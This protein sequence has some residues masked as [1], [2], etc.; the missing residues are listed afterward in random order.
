MKD[1]KKNQEEEN[2]SEK[3]D[4]QI[5]IIGSIDPIIPERKPPNHRIK[6]HSLTEEDK[7]DTK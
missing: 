6:N 4:D 1:K 7:I 3:K 5:K 2:D